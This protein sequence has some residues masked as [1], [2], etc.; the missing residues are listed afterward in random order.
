[1]RLPKTHIV[2]RV[3]DVARSAVFYEA[4]LGAAPARQGGGVAVFELES[5]PLL[6]AVEDRPRLRHSSARRPARFALV[7]SQPQ[8]IGDAAI[9]L[10]RRGIRLRVEDQGI[11]AH[12]PDGNVWR[13]RFVPSAE[14]PAVVVT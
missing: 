7:L 2:L 4:L 10:R 9:R 8:H 11:E 12:D 1:M 6:L 3:D 14:S 13:V 5:P